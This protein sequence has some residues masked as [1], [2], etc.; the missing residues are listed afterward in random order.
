MIKNLKI[1]TIAHFGEKMSTL[2]YKQKQLE[3]IKTKISEIE[4]PNKEKKGGFVSI[5]FLVGFLIFTSFFS[6]NQNLVYKPFNY[7]QETLGL[8]ECALC[9]QVYKREKSLTDWVYQYSGYKMI[10]GNAASQNNTELQLEIDA[11][12]HGLNAQA[13]NE[14]ILMRKEFVPIT[15]IPLDYLEKYPLQHTGG[16]NAK[17]LS[18]SLLFIVIKCALILH[19]IFKLYGFF[20]N[21]NA[22]SSIQHKNGFHKLS[23]LK[24]KEEKLKNYIIEH[25]SKMK[26]KG[27]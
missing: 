16:I 20:R 6:F 3:E 23:K 27:Q 15:D 14:A 10:E 12:L 5:Y 17:A 1:Y 24:E 26:E 4:K 21:S 18:I 19:I 22:Q 2:D 7:W 9:N 8:E 25:K 13:Q 11:I